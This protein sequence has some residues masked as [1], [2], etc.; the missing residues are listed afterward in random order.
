MKYQIDT[1]PVWD[2]YGKDTECPL[3][4]I[5]AQ[6]TE[7]EIRYFLGESVM[8]PDQRIEVN[9]DFFCGEHLRSLYAQ[10]NRLGLALMTHTYIKNMLPQLCAADAQAV[11]AVR[12]EALLPGAL[13]KKTRLAVAKLRD[14]SGKCVLCSR[15]KANM[16]RYAYTVLYLYGHDDEF[17]KTYENSRGF[18]M[19]HYADVLDMAAENAPHGEAASFTE[20]TARIQEKN[21]ERLMDE[22]EDFTRQFDYR[23]AGRS[24]GSSKDSVKRSVEK[25][26]CGVTDGDGGYDR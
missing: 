20:T 12:K 2:A 25:L 1:A 21:L 13:R 8:E 6:V 26:R 22:V 14:M 5:E 18:C 9:R 24:W 10:A 3:C 17:K 7:R 4:A 16:D 19:K 23:N 15:L 11:Q